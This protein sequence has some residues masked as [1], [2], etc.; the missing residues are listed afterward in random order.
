MIGE[1]FRADS[2]VNF[3]RGVV[4]LKEASRHAVEMSR[5]RFFFALG[6]V[7]V[8]LLSAIPVQTGN[9]S[10]AIS[11][12]YFASTCAGSSWTTYLGSVGRDSSAV[13]E[14]S[15]A[16]TTA[17]SI[18]PIW[19]Y[20]TG[21]P[22][23]AEPIL[24]RS[25][26]YVGSWNGYEYAFNVSTG[27]LLW[28]TNLG[29]DPKSNGSMGITSGAT[30]LGSTLYLG[31]GDSNFYALNATSG[32][33]V[34]K[35]GWENGSAGYYN[36]A[37]PLIVDGFA[38]LGVSSLDDAAVRG[39]LL[40]VSLATHKLVHTFYTSAPNTVGATVW[41]SPSFDA[42]LNAVFITTG[43]PVANSTSN[44]ESILELNAS[45]LH[46]LSKWSIPLNQTSPDG[47]MAS[48]PM[49][50][51]TASGLRLVAA[52]DKNGLTYAWNESKLSRGP[53]WSFRV[54][55]PSTVTLNGNLGPTAFGGNRVFVATEATNL[56]GHPYNGSVQA[57]DAGTGKLAWADPVTAGHVFY[58]PTYANGVVIFGA[59]SNFTALN[60]SN[61]HT[62]YTFVARH[63]AAYWGSA[64]VA[65]GRV[66]V[67]TSNGIIYAF[68]VGGCSGAALSIGG[69]VGE[70]SEWQSV[71]APRYPLTAQATGTAFSKLSGRR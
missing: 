43:N 30:L 4:R 31:G 57:L 60:G 67:G 17:A 41:T 8:V 29:T 38:Y 47:D 21:R 36:W 58:A 51:R 33:V 7:G 63:K 18:Q 49:I 20:S 39:A 35:V 15:I 40:Q 22:V 26:A 27:K 64:A 12:S 68:A 24:T 59:G 48:T 61:G 56:S 55:P 14:V 28:K 34:W 1:T 42:K 3:S 44:G 25:A 19:N 16:P 65:Y 6:L 2:R 69:Q 10:R 70:S 53:V 62:L 52:S 37:S 50:Y 66:V 46:L 71:Q 45:S 9:A 13:G 32:K 23:P 5:S 11:W 54:A